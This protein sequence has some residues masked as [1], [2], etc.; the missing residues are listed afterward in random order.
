[1]PTAITAA[2]EAQTGLAISHEVTEPR[3]PTPVSLTFTA[4]SRK[5]NATTTADEVGSKLAVSINV[6]MATAVGYAAMAEGLPVA[7]EGFAVT[8]LSTMPT[9]ITGDVVPTCSDAAQRTTAF[10]YFTKPFTPAVA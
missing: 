9:S 4:A 7:Q 8:S 2:K 5:T 10:T 1:M 6:G 3:R